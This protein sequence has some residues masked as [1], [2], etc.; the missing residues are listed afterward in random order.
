MTSVTKI[1]VKKSNGCDEVKS[2]AILAVSIHNIDAY[3]E[4]NEIHKITTRGPQEAKSCFR[5]SSNKSLIAWLSCVVF[6]NKVNK[7]VSDRSYVQVCFP[8]VAWGGH[9]L[10][11]GGVGRGL[12]HFLVL[13]I[14]VHHQGN[15]LDLLVLRKLVDG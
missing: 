15:F 13:V 3:V 5:L 14:G 6:H 9:F 2:T 11:E 8:F 1:I 4:D 10:C 12:H 7:I